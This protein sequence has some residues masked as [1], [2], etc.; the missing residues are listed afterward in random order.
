MNK[1]DE[2]L[3]HPL[4][5]MPLI[6]GQCIGLGNQQENEIALTAARLAMFFDTDGFVTI[7]VRQKIRR[8]G[9]IVRDAVMFPH[10]GLVNTSAPLIEWAHAAFE[11]LEIAH[12]LK[13]FSVDQMKGSRARRPQGRIVIQGLRRVDKLLPYLLPFLVGKQR[14]GQIVREF[15]DRRLAASPKATYADRD[16]ELANEVRALNSNKSG[17]WRP[18]SSETLCRTAELRQH[19]QKIKSDLR[20]DMQSTA[21]MTVPATHLV[22]Q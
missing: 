9:Q 19:L 4:E 20:G 5:P 7:Q 2:M 16:L 21:E 12:Y 13:W 17:E 8:K 22:A 11:R 10:L 6:T 3:E 15:I 14:Q 1:S 18:I